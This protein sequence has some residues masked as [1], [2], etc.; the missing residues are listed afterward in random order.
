MLVVI[1]GP[2]GV[3]KDTVAQRLCELD[4][5]LVVSRSWTTRARRAGEPADAYVFVSR[6]EFEANIAAGGF[7]EW[8][9]YH[10]HLY[11]TPRP[12]AADPRHVIL[13]I[14]VQGARQVLAQAPADTFMIL[15]EPPSEEVQAA[16]LRARGD[17]EDAVIRRVSAAQVELADGRQLAHAVVVNDD[18]TRAVEDVRRILEGCLSRKN[19]GDH[20]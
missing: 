4:P 15:L 14:E 16:R 1:A 9:E 5:R 3:G 18:L 10:G 13:V 20:G 7:M 17:D 2:G 12:D 6:E 19:Q 8:A 11:G